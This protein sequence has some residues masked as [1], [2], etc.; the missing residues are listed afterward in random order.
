MTEADSEIVGEEDDES[1][2]LE[3]PARFTGRAPFLG[4]LGVKVE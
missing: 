1:L 2:G 3:P 4:G